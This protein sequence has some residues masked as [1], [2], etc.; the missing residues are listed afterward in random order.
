MRILDGRVKTGWRR[1][2]LG[3]GESRKQS[4]YDL[5]ERSEF[6]QRQ[7]CHA[8]NSSPLP[9]AVN[10][11][12]DYFRDAN[13]FPHAKACKEP[14]LY[15]TAVAIPILTNIPIPSITDY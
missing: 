10:K 6:A 11:M 3:I 7:I 5:S 2:G 4:S 8:P 15:I 13:L 12:A 1:W 14:P 9:L